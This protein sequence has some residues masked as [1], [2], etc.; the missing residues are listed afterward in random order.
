MHKHGRDEKL[1]WGKE[2]SVLTV[3]INFLILGV[4]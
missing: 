3:I 4:Y 2:N 1:V